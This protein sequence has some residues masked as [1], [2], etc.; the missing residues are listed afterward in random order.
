[1]RSIKAVLPTIGAGL[2]HAELGEVQDG[3]G[4]QKAYLEAVSEGTG[5][6]RKTE[7]EEGV[8]RYCGMDIEA[9]VALAGFLGLAR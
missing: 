7:V 6:E 5:E 3:T 8:R 1:S 4:A 2:D 9:M